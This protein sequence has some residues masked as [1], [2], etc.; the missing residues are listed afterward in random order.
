[1]WVPVEAELVETYGFSYSFIFSERLVPG[2][3]Q[4]ALFL[5]PP[6]F[7]VCQGH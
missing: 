1:M 7:N 2:L 5:V 3:F 6:G 4:G